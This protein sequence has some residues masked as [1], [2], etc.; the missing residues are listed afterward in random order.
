MKHRAGIGVVIRDHQG[1]VIASLSQNIALPHFVAEVEA[2]A[3][4][5]A[6]KFARELGI[7]SAIIKGDSELV[8]NF[9]KDVLPSHAPFGFLI[10][11]AKVFE[12]SLYCLRF[13][14]VYRE[15]NFVAHNFA[16]HVIHIIDFLV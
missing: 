13:S 15:R 11:D 16:R 5:R 7:D 10:Q 2:M 6:L 1:L 9:L 8:I 4:A 3:A 14:H 12:E